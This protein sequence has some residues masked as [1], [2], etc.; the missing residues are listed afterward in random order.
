M[1]ISS[2][3]KMQIVDIKKSFS[4]VIEQYPIFETNVLENKVVFM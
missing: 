3:M 4:K 1:K 2:K